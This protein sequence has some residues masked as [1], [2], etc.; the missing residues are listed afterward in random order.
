MYSVNG[1]WI[2]GETHLPT[3]TQFIPPPIFQLIRSPPTEISAHPPPL[4]IAPLVRGKVSL[5]PGRKN[6][7]SRRICLAF[8]G[9]VLSNLCVSQSPKET[10]GSPMDGWNPRKGSPAFWRVLKLEMVAFGIPGQF[11]GISTFVFRKCHGPIRVEMSRK[12][13]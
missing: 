12:N 1:R 9:G 11:D 4:R 6:D 3:E 5:R 10:N 7:I 13:E 8:G 2:F